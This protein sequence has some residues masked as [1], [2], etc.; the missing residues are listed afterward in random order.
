MN[1]KFVYLVSD[2]WGNYGYYATNIDGNL[3]YEENFDSIENGTTILGTYN[4][5]D[6]AIEF[7]KKYKPETIDGLDFFEIRSFEFSL[8]E[9]IRVLLDKGYSDRSIEY[10]L[11]TDLGEINR[12]K[13]AIPLHYDYNTYT[14]ENSMMRT[15]Y[16]KELEL[17]ID[18]TMD[19]CYDRFYH[20]IRVEIIGSR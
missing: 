1:G 5:I 14:V 18:E 7:A 11:S 2:D 6:D 4:D 10:I 20:H 15:V 19:I 9:K 8:C 3:P 16:E 12:A 13:A 17:Q